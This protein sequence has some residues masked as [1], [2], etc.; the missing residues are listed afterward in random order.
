MRCLERHDHKRRWTCWEAA[1]IE[2][3]R[4][5]HSWTFYRRCFMEQVSTR[6]ILGRLDR[7][8]NVHH[9]PSHP[10]DCSIN[11]GYSRQESKCCEEA[12]WVR[13]AVET[14]LLMSR[15]QVSQAFRQVLDLQ[16]LHACWGTSCARTRTE[17]ESRQVWWFEAF[18][19]LE[20]QGS[21]PALLQRMSDGHKVQ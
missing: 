6:W 12:N 11:D 21:C 18:S 4:C 17:A 3:S 7:K 15:L 1:A 16:T 9:I 5:S 13:E 10:C 20:T 14:W 2:A 8:G 19:E